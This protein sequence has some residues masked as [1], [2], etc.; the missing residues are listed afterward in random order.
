MF[1]GP[2][3]LSDVAAE[4]RL[5][6]TWIRDEA[7]A[8]RLPCLRVGRTRLFSLAA[9]REAL[10]R[11]AASGDSTNETGADAPENLEELYK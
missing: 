7:D 3:R 6:R 5:P 2:M 8:G 4:L 9:V 1:D 11:R 10:E